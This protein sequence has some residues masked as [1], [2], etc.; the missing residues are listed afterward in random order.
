MAILAL[1][2]GILLLSITIFDFIYTTLSGGGSGFISRYINLFSHKSLNIGVKIFGRNFYNQSGIILN[3]T[4]LLVWVVLIWL[5]LFL[6]FSYRPE[7]IVNNE[8]RPA[9]ITE[10][11]YFTGYVLST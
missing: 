7:A 9:S 4:L 8:G 10:R 11:V 1:I 6:I 5:G 3:V 2:T